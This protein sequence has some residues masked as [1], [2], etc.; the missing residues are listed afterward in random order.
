MMQRDL[1][2][3]GNVFVGVESMYVLWIMKDESR[4]VLDVL[5]E[6]AKVKPES[7]ATRKII[8]QPQRRQGGMR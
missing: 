8:T 2:Q 3:K 5:C 7:D 6:L 4:A 1:V